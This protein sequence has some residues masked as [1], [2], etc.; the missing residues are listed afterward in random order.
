MVATDGHRLA[1]A[2]S[3]SRSSAPSPSRVL[4]PRKAIHELGGLLEGADDVSRSRRE[5]HLLFSGRQRTLA[6][7]TIEGQFPAF[8]KVDRA[9]RRQAR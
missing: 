9:E 2:R 8:E 4:V 1:Y 5:N 6:S 7:K 3:K